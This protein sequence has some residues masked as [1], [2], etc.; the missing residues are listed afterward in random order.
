LGLLFAAALADLGA[1][2]EAGFGAGATVVRA[3]VDELVLRHVA[4][5]LLYHLVQSTVVEVVFEVVL[6]APGVLPVG[7]WAA[8]VR[9]AGFVAFPGLVQS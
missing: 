2:V 7:D 4:R 9:Q 1:E 3:G 6:T 8:A 5:A